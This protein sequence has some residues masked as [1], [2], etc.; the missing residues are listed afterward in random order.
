MAEQVLDRYVSFCGIECDRWAEELMSML[1]ESL[2]QTSVDQRWRAYFEKKLV[3]RI[4]LGQDELFFVGAQMN[5]LY[6][7]FE[8]ASNEEAKTLLWN[9]EQQCC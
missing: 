2:S 3:E 8:Q 1:E 7:L 5:N 9:L 4:K 6:T